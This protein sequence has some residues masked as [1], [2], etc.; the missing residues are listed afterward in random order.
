MSE[1]LDAVSDW[2][3]MLSLS[4]EEQDEQHIKIRG[5][6]GSATVTLEESE[7]GYTLETQVKPFQEKIPEVIAKALGAP[8]SEDRQS[9]Q[10]NTQVARRTA[11]NAAMTA[12]A[13]NMPTLEEVR[14][15][16]CPTATDEECQFAL[17][18]CQVRG[19]N[20]FL[21]D[22]YLVKYG[23]QN[24]KLE[25]IVSKNYFLKKAESYANFES[26]KAGVIVQKGDEFQEV[27][28]SFAYPG[29][30]L[31][32][33]W[34][35]LK[36]KDRSV[37]YRQ[38]IALENFIKENKFWRT[39]PGAGHMIRKTAVSLVIKEAYPA[40]LGGLFDETEM[41]GIDVAYEVVE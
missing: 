27:E 19:L 6:A 24:P 12:L 14:S 20:P 7:Q 25:I 21:G 17:K 31:I 1:I 26:L 28:R 2:A 37:P 16:F 30:K 8:K 15:C 34:A 9:R 11:S 18:V 29:E 40:E 22:C 33:G 10:T 23:G 41:G 36:R 4:I 35:E 32:G 3:G 5:N 38:A 13:G 39:S